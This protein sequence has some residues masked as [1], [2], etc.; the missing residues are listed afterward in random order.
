ML[1][2][3][4]ADGKSRLAEALDAGTRRALAEAMLADVVAATRSAGLTRIVLV[5][6]GPPARAAGRRLG[7]DVVDDPDDGAGLDAALLHAGRRVGGDTLVLAADLPAL[8]RDDVTALI[9]APTPVVVAPTRGGGTAALL[10]RPDGCL[11]PAYGIGSAARHLAAATAAG[12]TALIIDRPGLAHD[13]D[14]PE[15]LVVPTGLVLG[16]ATAAVLAE[17]GNRRDGA[18][19]TG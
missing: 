19:A 3:L 12:L 17:L 18:G 2:P 8:G 4:R 11:A 13:V 10:R 5:A 7:L 14:R 6:G 16:P 1:V 9:E 15:D